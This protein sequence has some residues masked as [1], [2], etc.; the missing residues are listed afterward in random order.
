MV[1]PREMATLSELELEKSDERD[2]EG[3]VDDGSGFTLEE[4]LRLGG[5][6]VR[7]RP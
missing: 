7:K 5:T 3:E 1:W 6:K 4:V 2:G